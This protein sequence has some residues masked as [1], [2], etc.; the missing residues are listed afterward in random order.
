[1]DERRRYQRYEAS[2]ALRLRTDEDTI[3]GHVVD[4]S[5]FGICLA[6]APTALVRVGKAYD[7]EVLHGTDDR[8]RFRCTGEVRY[9]I[10]DRVGI[11]TRDL[12]PFG[13]PR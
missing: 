7:L 4:V 5:D 6:I 1:M 13:R 2:W 11:E 8:S 9:I 3:S 10:G 12:L